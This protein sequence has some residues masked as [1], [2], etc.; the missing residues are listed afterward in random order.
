MST[1]TQSKYYWAQCGMLHY[2]KGEEL[3]HLFYYI[4]FINPKL[5]IVKY[6]PSKMPMGTHIAA[7]A[8][9]DM[10]NKHITEEGYEVAKDIFS[11]H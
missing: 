4:L 11:R 7:Q 10:L 3:E 9:Q 5:K 2:N 1:E 8:L 6:Y